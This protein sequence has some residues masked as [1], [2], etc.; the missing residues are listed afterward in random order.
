LVAGLVVSTDDAVF[1][2]FV[3]PGETVALSWR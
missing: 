1:V 2:G 3:V